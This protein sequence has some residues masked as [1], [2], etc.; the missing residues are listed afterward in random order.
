MSSYTVVLV[1]YYMLCSSSLPV[2]P[3]CYLVVSCDVALSAMLRHR[4]TRL[5]HVMWLYLPC[6]TLALLCC[7]M[8]CGSSLPVTPP[9]YLVVSCGCTCAV[10]RVHTD[11][12]DTTWRCGR[13]KLSNP[14]PNWHPHRKL[15]CSS[16]IDIHS[17]VYARR[18]FNLRLSSDLDFT[19]VSVFTGVT[20]QVWRISRHAWSHIAVQVSRLSVVE[21]Y[22]VRLITTTS[23]CTK[24]D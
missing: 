3:S 23:C 16:V 20:R 11:F 21:S 15:P 9:F 18:V 12:L 14:P 10:W 22:A 13:G 19:V 7:Y 5:L 1:G 2:T 6:Y 24:I 8:L 4:V 17:D